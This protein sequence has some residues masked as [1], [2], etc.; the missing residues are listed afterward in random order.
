MN[1][2]AFYPI[3]I[4]IFLSL[5][6][7]SCSTIERSVSLG[8]ISGVATGAIVA[9]GFVRHEKKQALVIG[10]ITGL[11]IGGIAG[12]FTHKGLENRDEKIRKETLF[13]M[14]NY[15]L[16]KPL[17]P[18]DDTPPSVLNPKV[19][20]VWVEPKI[21]NG[22]YIQGHFIWV[23]TDEARWNEGEMKKKESNKEKEN[24]KEK[25]ENTNGN[26]KGGN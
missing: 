23:I 7:L 20:K 17:G 16:Q 24:D 4:A 18:K 6:L 12:Y 13:N 1:K 15:G 3:I 10:A 21:E 22:K 5:N 14:E 25:T 26:N 8:A 2:H 9:P 19:E 11:A